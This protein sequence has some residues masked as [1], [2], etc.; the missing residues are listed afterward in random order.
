MKIQQ[1]TNVNANTV[2]LN[3]LEN[4]FPLCV[5]KVILLNSDKEVS[6]ENV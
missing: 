6:E 4:D 3:K 1:D 5:L 2:K